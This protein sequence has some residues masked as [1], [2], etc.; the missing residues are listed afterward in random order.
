MKSQKK[1]ERKKKKRVD[2]FHI[3]TV[4]DLPVGGAVDLRVNLRLLL[5]LQHPPGRRGD[6]ELLV[7]AVAQA[8]GDAACMWGGARVGR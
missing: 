4:P 7:D 5:L 8:V 3:K 6:K 1:K 2:F